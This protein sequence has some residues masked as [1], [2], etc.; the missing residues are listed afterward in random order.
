MGI[1]LEKLNFNHF[2]IKILRPFAVNY[3]NHSTSLAILKEVH[4]L[5]RQLGNKP[6]LDKKTEN[7]NC[8]TY[9]YGCDSRR[10]GINIA[11]DKARFQRNYGKN[12]AQHQ[13]FSEAFR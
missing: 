13:K 9:Q 2:I 6:F 5:S 1:L 4:R 10:N 8:G 11:Y 12:H 7:E 3:L